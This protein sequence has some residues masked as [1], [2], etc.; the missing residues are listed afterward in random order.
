[1][2]GTGTISLKR[3]GLQ[4]AKEFGWTDQQSF[5]DTDEDA[6]KNLHTRNQTD[7]PVCNCRRCIR[8]KHRRKIDRK[9][10]ELGRDLDHLEIQAAHNEV[11]DETTVERRRVG[12]A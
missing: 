10:R 7:I 3:R 8:W 6:L 9:R 12:L 4:F 2:N 1:M 5:K 11:L